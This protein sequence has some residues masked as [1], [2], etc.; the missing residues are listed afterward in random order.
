M[1][2][3]RVYFNQR[4]GSAYGSRK[5]RSGQCGGWVVDGGT[6][7]CLN[8]QREMGVSPCLTARGLRSVAAGKPVGRA[9]A[10]TFRRHRSGGPLQR[11][12]LADV[13]KNSQLFTDALSSYTG[14]DKRCRHEVIDHAFEYVRGEVHTNSIEKFWALFKRCIKGTYISVM[15]FLL[16]ADLD[17]WVFRFD[18]RRMTGGERFRNVL[19]NVAGRRIQYSELIARG[20]D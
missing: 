12:V 6:S 11:H 7:V 13:G 3:T 19:A 20:R 16:D 10:P 14:L 9:G 4:R 15:P 17:E 8:K 2:E 1:C 18:E 5:V